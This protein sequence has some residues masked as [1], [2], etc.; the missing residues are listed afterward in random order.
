MGNATLKSDAD[1]ALSNDFCYK[2]R[3]D[4]TL[5]DDF[6]KNN[7]DEALTPRTNGSDKAMKR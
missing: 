5:N 6:K 3:S 7:A 1:Q 2:K 4:E